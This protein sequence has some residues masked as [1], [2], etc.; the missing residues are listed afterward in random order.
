MKFW[1]S[2]MVFAWLA[3]DRFFVPQIVTS[4]V[5]TGPAKDEKGKSQFERFAVVAGAGRATG[6][7]LEL[8]RPRSLRLDGLCWACQ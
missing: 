7:I 8:Q 5:L 2:I 4:V 6:E 3:S 1:G